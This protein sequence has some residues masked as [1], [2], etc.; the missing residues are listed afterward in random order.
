MVQF[1]VPKKNMPKIKALL[2][3]AIAILVIFAIVP[4]INTT[5]AVINF[6]LS[7]MRVIASA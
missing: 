3:G 5:V 7:A 4:S 1:S 2:M 6:K